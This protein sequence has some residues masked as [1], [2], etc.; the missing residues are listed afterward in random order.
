MV[1]GQDRLKRNAWRELRRGKLPIQDELDLHGCT[2][3]EARALLQE[4][5]IYCGEEGFRCVRI[6]H[7][8]GT[9]SGPAGPVIKQAVKQWLRSWESVLAFCPAPRH[10]G[11][12]GAV[13]VLLQ[14]R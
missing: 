7:G 3:V 1:Y 4:F 9:R 5:L 8:K 12:S 6:V 10:D 2:R 13:Y 14:S 11:G